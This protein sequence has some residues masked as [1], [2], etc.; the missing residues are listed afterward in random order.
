MFNIF[1]TMGEPTSGIEIKT[2]ENKMYT[3]LMKLS[4][5]R[6][7]FLLYFAYVCYSS[8]CWHLVSLVLPLVIYKRRN[9]EN[10]TSKCSAHIER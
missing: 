8:L 4:C 5:E 10:Q 1:C 2:Y 3:I 6:V 9:V 7:I